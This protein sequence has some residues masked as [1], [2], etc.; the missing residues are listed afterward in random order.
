M[1]KRLIG[2]LAGLVA[3]A[4]LGLGIAPA[5]A[6][7]GGEPD[8]DL[9]PDVGL[10]LFYAEDGRF[11]CSATLVS[12]TVVV[13]AAHCTEGTLG[14]TLVTFESVIAEQPPSGFPVAADPTVGYTSAELAAAGYISGTAYTHPAY[15]GFTDMDNWNDVGVIVLDAPVA[16]FGDGYPEVAPVGTLDAIKQS[17]LSKTLFTA[18]GYGTE[19]RKPDAGPQ[20][21]Q[22]MTYPLLRRYVDMPGQKLTPQILQT[23]GNPNDVHG[24]GG[25]CFGDSGGPVYLGDQIVAVT[26]YGYTSNCRYLG[27]YQRLDIPVVADWLA[28]FGV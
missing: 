3:I 1:N 19:V 24:T 16:S 17:D 13:T 14:S 20:K 2:G 22:P 6:T 18:V 8:G 25:T 4:S 28:T 11:R 26:S 27:G 23:N 7:T 12:P 15:S 9:H 5:N 21:P 10:I